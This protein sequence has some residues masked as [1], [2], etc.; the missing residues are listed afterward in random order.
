MRCR[1]DRWAICRV[2][3]SAST[4]HHRLGPVQMTDAARSA[5]VA[6]HEDKQGRLSRELIEGKATYGRSSTRQRELPDRHRRCRA[7]KD[8]R[9]HCPATVSERARSPADLLP[10]KGETCVSDAPNPAS[11]LRTGRDTAHEDSL[12]A[13]RYTCSM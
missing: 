7:A 3:R 1:L 8:Q 2:A 10:A 4:P 9:R 13:T 6:P 11:S 12:T 5:S